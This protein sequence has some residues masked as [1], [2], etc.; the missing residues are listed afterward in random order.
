[1]T[2]PRKPAPAI[3]NQNAYEEEFDFDGEK[4]A[5]CQMSDSELAEH[6]TDCEAAV[7]TANGYAMSPHFWY[8][9]ACARTEW[10]HRRATVIE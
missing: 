1:M 9:L 3:P 2:R 8:R 5:V 4:L 7:R 6:E 10:R